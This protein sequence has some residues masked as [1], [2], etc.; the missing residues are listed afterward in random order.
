MKNENEY[1]PFVEDQYRPKIY[2]ISKTDIIPKT[3]MNS[4]N[5]DSELA[6]R[7]NVLDLLASFLNAQDIRENSKD[8]YRKGLNRFMAWLEANRITQPDR[9]TILKFKAYLNEQ[10]LSPNTINGYLVPVKRFFAYLEGLRKYPDIAKNI[11]G[12]KQARGYLREPLTVSQLRGL[13]DHIDTSTLR[14]KRDFA[15]VNLMARTGLRTIEI[16]RADAGDLRQDGG[17]ALLYIQGK[18]RDAKDAF[19]VLTEKALG[20]ILGYLKG[21]G[22]EIPGEGPLFTSISDRNKGKRLTTRTI[23]QIVKDALAHIDIKDRKL[24]AHSLRHT[25]ATLALAAGAPL[26]QVKDALRHSSIE[27][28]Q[29]YTHNLDRITKAAERYLDF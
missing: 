22:G 16:I 10:K 24:T 2:K 19:V 5:R 1:L 26:I 29:R 4:E 8:A 6:P 7:I 28:T 25:F 17:E 13:L 15:I 11:K 18:G 20:P 3:G 27:T 21:R 9:E 23:R 14:G 12:A